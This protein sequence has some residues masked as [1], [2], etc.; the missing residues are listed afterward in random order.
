MAQRLSI[1]K[2]LLFLALLL[3]A[4]TVLAAAAAEIVLRVG[5]GPQLRSMLSIARLMHYRNGAGLLLTPGM[6]VTHT[7]ASGEA[8]YPIRINRQG[9]RADR[10]YA[11]APAADTKRL[12]VM[13]DSFTFGIGVPVEQT[14]AARLEALLNDNTTD[15]RFEVINTGFASGNCALPQFLYLKNRGLA[16][17]PQVV[18]VG[19]YADNDLR[20]MDLYRE[21][22][23]DDGLP[24]ALILPSGDLPH[25]LKRTALYQ[26]VGLQIVYP[27]LAR[28]LRAQTQPASSAEAPAAETSIRNL[29]RAM[30]LFAGMQRLASAQ[31]ARL[32]VMYIPGYHEVFAGQELPAARIRTTLAAT[33]REH[34]FAA[35]DLTAAIRVAGLEVYLP[36]DRHFSAVGHRVAAQVLAETLRSSHP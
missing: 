7:L 17:S 8:T 14:Y 32:V 25:W 9:L 28:L 3:A 16:F 1:G 33:A 4:L 34:G 36:I 23:G 22:P 18:V 2:K 31:G 30:E 21:T 13:G 24:A 10:E 35:I 15:S 5:A 19:F 12:L 6:R 11:P 29:R 26:W 20:D 27:R